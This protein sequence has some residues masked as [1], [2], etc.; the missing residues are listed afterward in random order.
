M[1]RGT[2]KDTAPQETQPPLHGT[3][4]PKDTVSRN[5]TAPTGHGIPRGHNR[6]LS[7]TPQGTEPTLGTR[8]PPTGQIFPHPRTGWH[9]R[10][11][12]LSPWDT[13]HP[14]QEPAP[15]QTPTKDPLPA[16][17][18]RTNPPEPLYSPRGGPGS[19]PRGSVGPVR[20]AARVAAGE[21]RG[22]SVSPDPGDPPRT[23]QPRSRSPAA[24]PP[25]GGDTGR[26]GSAP[27]GTG[28]AGRGKKGDTRGGKNPLGWRRPPRGW[29]EFQG[30]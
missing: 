10:G 18:L 3:R 29:G 20:G 25:A 9:P 14:S 21:G 4:I 24:A 16:A 8:I 2:P 11:T 30:G 12:P 1:R 7:D 27:E 28:P 17:S 15:H 5:S 23:P 13:C 26:D 22:A 19:L 6:P